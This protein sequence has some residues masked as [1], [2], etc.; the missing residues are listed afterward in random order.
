CSRL[1]WATP[2]SMNSTSAAARIEV[3]VFS[4]SSLVRRIDCFGENLAK[5]CRKPGIVGRLFTNVNVC[6]K[7]AS[8]A[9]NL[10]RQRFAAGL[11]GDPL[12]HA[13][14]LALGARRA[15]R[16]RAA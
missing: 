14:T 6:K 1:V 12:P 10:F 2:F 3:R 5:G 15:F 11:L 8:P 13:F 4:A 16:V 9:R 7:V